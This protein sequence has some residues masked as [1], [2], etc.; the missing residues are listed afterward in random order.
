MKA[1]DIAVL[2]RRSEQPPLRVG[3]LTYEADR[4]YW[5]YVA[6]PHSRRWTDYESVPAHFLLGESDP[7]LTKLKRR[8]KGA[9]FRELGG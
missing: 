7:S 5:R 1:R 8:L 2:C 3:L 6:D 4:R 9:I